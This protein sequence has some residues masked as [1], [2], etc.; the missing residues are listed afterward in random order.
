MKPTEESLIELVRDFVD[1]HG[2]VERN[3]Y[4][5]VASALG[6]GFVLGGGLFTGLTDRLAGTALRIGLVA[7]WPR[8]EDELN[9][10][11]CRSGEA[12]G[13]HNEKGETE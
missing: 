5:M 11:K 9:W 2:R 4:G 12:A 7:V 3:P 10:L 8:L 13:P 1:I 6:V